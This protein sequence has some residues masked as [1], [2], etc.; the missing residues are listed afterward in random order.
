MKTDSPP[1]VILHNGRQN[2]RVQAVENLS[3]DTIFVGAVVGALLLRYEL[4]FHS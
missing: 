2:G 3:E 4:R 1:D